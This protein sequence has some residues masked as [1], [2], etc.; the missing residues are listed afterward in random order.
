MIKANAN[1][2][3]P[4]TPATI[5]LRGL[6]ASVDMLLEEGLDKVFARHHRM[7]EA[8]RRAVAAWGLKLV[9]KAPKWHSDTVSAIY[10]PKGSTATKWSATRTGGLTWRSA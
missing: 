8:V 9:A 7:A 2:F 5:M 10:V 1:G 3:F 4:Y 6:R